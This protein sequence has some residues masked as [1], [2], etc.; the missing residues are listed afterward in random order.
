MDEQNH[1]ENEH[2]EHPGCKCGGVCK[3]TGDCG[4]H[5]LKGEEKEEAKSEQESAESAS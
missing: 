5:L 1:D 2:E 3:I 4:K